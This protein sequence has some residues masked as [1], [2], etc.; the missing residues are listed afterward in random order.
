[1][2][3]SS[4]AQVCALLQKLEE[5]TEKGDANRGSG[6][7]KV[8]RVCVTRIGAA[9]WSCMES[10]SQTEQSY[11]VILD[12]TAC[13]MLWLSRK[14]LCS[15]NGWIDGAIGGKDEECQAIHRN[16]KDDDGDYSK[17]DK[18]DLSSLNAVMEDG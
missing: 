5:A 8:F 11:Y 10:Q 16:G 7:S 15:R 18:W 1:M 17:A 12:R 9:C 14:V 6:G 2:G 13:K 4:A 3:R